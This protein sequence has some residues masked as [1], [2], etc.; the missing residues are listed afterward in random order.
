VRELLKE[1]FAYTMVP[2]EAVTIILAGFIVFVGKKDKKSAPYLCRIEVNT[3][4]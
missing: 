2:Q 4:A 1:K 3:A